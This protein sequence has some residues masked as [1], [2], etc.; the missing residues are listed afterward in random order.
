LR[1]AAGVV[2]AVQGALAQAV[3]ADVAAGR[4]AIVE[5]VA[6]DVAAG[7][8][9]TAADVADAE[10]EVTAMV[11]GTVTRDTDDADTTP[12]DTI[13]TAGIGMAEAATTARMSASVRTTASTSTTVISG[14]G[15]RR[16][17]AGS[18]SGS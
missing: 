18:C 9:A 10:A 14:S 12:A 3:V 17:P 2:V 8:E 5:A 1:S 7:R 16:S 13:T 6:E 4:E 11:V 15:E